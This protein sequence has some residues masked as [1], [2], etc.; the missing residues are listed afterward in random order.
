MKN[1]GALLLCLALAVPAQLAAGQEPAPA[2]A[3]QSIEALKQALAAI[4]KETNTPGISVALVSRDEILWADGI[5]LADVAA[6]T[7]ATANTLF[8]IGSTSKAFV[9]LAALK[10]RA[11]GRL[12][13]EATLASLAPE[14]PFENPWE[15]TRPVR[16]VHLLEHT[17]GFDDVHLRDYA[18]QPER[19][20]DLKT[21]LAFDPDSR[22]SRWPPGE[23]FAYCNAGPPIVAYVIEKITG[24]PFAEYV[25]QNFFGPIGMASASYFLTSKTEPLLTRLYAPDGVTPYPYWH[26]AMWPSGSIDAS[27][28]DMAAYVRFYLNRGRVGENVVLSEADVQRLETPGS[29]AAARAGLTTVGYGLYSFTS[30]GDEDGFVYYGHSGGV[31]G[32]GSM[33]AYR[34]DAGV[35][36]AFMFN[37]A[38]GAAVQ[39][40][41]KLIRAYLARGLEKPALPAAVAIADDVAERYAGFYVPTNPRSQIAAFA[42][43]ISGVSR[44]SFADGVAQFG[45]L[46][47]RSKRYVGVTGNLLRRDDQS[48]ATL[49]LLPVGDDGV[50]IAT[51]FVSLRRTSAPLALLPPFLAAFAGLMMLSS[52]LFAPVWGVRALRGRIALRPQLGLRLWPLA[53]TLVML[54]FLGGMALMVV[55]GKIFQHYATINAHSLTL[56]AL[57]VLVVLLPLAGLFALSRPA[58]RGAH[59]GLFWHA[60]LVLAG[61]SVLALCLAS[62][63]AVP[64]VTWN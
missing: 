14:I 37:A 46:F 19:I 20:E 16:I 2:S 26:I 5:G 43:R 12:D 4:L 47:T 45:G 10:L 60:A 7:P 54:G 28:K 18:Y 29:T 64:F 50:G 9:A 62:L 3:P 31:Q 23:R 59:R 61:I 49:A 17:A 55:D 52:L 30:V 22:T 32:G 25:Q 6:N 58:Y 13:F 15:A 53:A 42:A 8:R 24:Q 40:I 36:Y 33:M 56:L 41:N 38:N 34:P 27:A 44:L 21:T 57:S 11:E 48:V 1:T 35:G 39:K 63:G 51:G